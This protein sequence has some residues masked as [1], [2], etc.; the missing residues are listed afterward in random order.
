MFQFLKPLLSSYVL[1][2]KS[3]Y[4][5]YSSG[6]SKGEVMTLVNIFKRTNFNCFFYQSANLDSLNFYDSPVAW[7]KILYKYVVKGFFF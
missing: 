7:K 2:K 4:I 6:F 3:R 1:Y 5:N